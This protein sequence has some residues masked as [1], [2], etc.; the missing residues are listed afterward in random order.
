MELRRRRLCLDA[1]VT[2]GGGACACT[3]RDDACTDGDHHAWDHHR[4]GVHRV[5]SGEFSILAESG[6]G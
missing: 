6:E 5:F 4:F 1:D 2:N 3:R